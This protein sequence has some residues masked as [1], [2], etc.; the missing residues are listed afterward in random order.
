MSENRNLRWILPL[1]VGIFIAAALSIGSIFG[2]RKPNSTVTLAA[3]GDVLLARGVG[4]Q[5]EKNGPDWVFE[6]VRS[7]IKR[8]DLAFCN[9][10]CP[11]S[12]GGV[13]KR[14]RFCFR[15]DPKLA[16]SLSNNGF[17]I[18]SLANN[19]TLDYGRD[20]LIDTV[21]AVHNAEMVEVGAG[22]G[23]ADALKLKIVEKKGLKIG[24]LAFTDLPTDGVVRLSNKPT[25]A[26]VNL[27]EL[28]AQ[29]ASDRDKCDVLVVSFHW[30][31]EYMKRPTERQQKIAHICIDNG[32]DLVLG[33]HPHVLQRI[34]TYK[35]K[36]ILYS[37]GGFAWDAK[38]FDADKSAIY[39]VELS[40]RSAKLIKLMPVK[41]EKCRP[42]LVA[43]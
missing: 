35:G 8:A 22:R 23:R 2:A 3:V 24:F 12:T 18:V 6:D 5:I 13:S 19:H 29:I 34:E 37:M 11:L 26:G 41:S 14:R 31:I 32:A 42:V 40:K 10:E 21:N 38:I 25:V 16:K 33:H 17:D 20:S 43:K 4:K 9:L 36:P 27:D 1:F 28:P 15:A 30:G 7:T 39:M